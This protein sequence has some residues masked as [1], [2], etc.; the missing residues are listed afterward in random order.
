MLD[1]YDRDADETNTDTSM[2]LNEESIAVSAT[3][4]IMLAN[5]IEHNPDT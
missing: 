2:D 4:A 5:P 1:L 3:S